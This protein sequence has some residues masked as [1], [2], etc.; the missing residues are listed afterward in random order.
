MSEEMR[1]FGYLCSACWQTVMGTRSVVS[2]EA[3]Y[4][5]I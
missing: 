5:E 1:T 2:L 3:S 4:A